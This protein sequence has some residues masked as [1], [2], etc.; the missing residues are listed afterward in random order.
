M[1]KQT[2]VF[3]LTIWITIYLVILILNFIIPQSL[4]TKIISCLAISLNVLYSSQRSPKD[5]LLQIALGFTFLADVILAFHNSAFLG[6]FVFAFAQFFHFAR[7]NTL[8][9]RH[10][11]TFL[12]FLTILVYLS[13][14][15]GLE[16]T[17]IIGSFYAFFLC[18]NLINSILWYKKSHSLPAFRSA[19]G[20]T[21]FVLCDLCVATSY[22]SHIGVFSIA[23]FPYADYLSWVFY[24]PSQ[25]FIANSSK[26]PKSMIK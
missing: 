19:L 3:W 16:Q 24:Y 7:L 2:T 10:F 17:I 13:S 21:L 22:F 11:L 4:A 9:S 15:L 12:L 20:F 1:K 14:L 8:D 26:N 6:A 25:I 18:A 23:L 5:H